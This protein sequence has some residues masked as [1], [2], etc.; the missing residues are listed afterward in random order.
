M[1]RLYIAWQDQTNRRWLPVGQLTQDGQK[2]RFSYTKGA[3]C[4]DRFRPFGFM[5]DLEIEYESKELFPLFTNRL[6]EKSRPEYTEFLKWLNL[7]K[8]TASPFS[9]LSITGGAKK[10]DP[11][12]LF[13]CPG[14]N[15]K[16]QYEVNFLSRGIRYLPPENQQ[17]INKLKPGDRLY[18]LKDVQ[19]IYD[20]KALLMRTDDPMSIAG[21]CPMYFNDD[22]NRLLNQSETVS[23]TVIRVNPD[24]PYQ[25]RL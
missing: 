12:E 6:M 4:S 18:L 20:A 1:K 19:N 16:N 13:P 25:M 17:Q 24:A 5:K 22:F 11:L 3:T 21:Y 15:E 10:T 8:E 2:F 7:S 23:V 9:I 14:P